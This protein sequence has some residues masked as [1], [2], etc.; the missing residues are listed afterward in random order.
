MLEVKTALLFISRRK[1]IQTYSPFLQPHLTLSTNSSVEYFLLQYFSHHCI[2]V[3][4]LWDTATAGVRHCYCSRTPPVLGDV[5]GE[6]RAGQSTST[7][8]ST[9][10]K[11]CL[12]QV[13]VQTFF[14]AQLCRKLPSVLFLC[15]NQEH[16]LCPLHWVKQRCHGKTPH[17]C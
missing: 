9:F 16:K 4:V 11:P 1:A 10:S 6:R 7:E 14:P 5:D 12:D 15:R 8:P 2:S 13:Q 3:C 17:L